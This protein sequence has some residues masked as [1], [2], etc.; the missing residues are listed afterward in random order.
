MKEGQSPI[1]LIVSLSVLLLFIC[2]V[3]GFFLLSPE[4]TSPAMA[5]IST[6][7]TG[8]AALDATAPTLSQGFTIPTVP[9]NDAIQTIQTFAEANSLMLEDYPAKLIA[10][11]ERNPETEEFVLNY[12]LEYGVEHEIDMSEYEDCENVPLFMQ[13]DRRWGYLDYAGEVAGLSGCGPVCL[14]MAAYYLTKDPEMSPDKIIQ[15]AIDHGYAVNGNGSAWSLISEGGRALGLNVTEI[16][17]NKDRVLANLEAGNLIICVMGPGYFT[18]SGHFILMSGTEDGL[19]RI[20]DP[21]SYANSQKLWDFQDIQNQ[22]LN[23]W[24]LQ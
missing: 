2:A 10:M 19:I 21:N 17:I 14:S 5:S 1:G 23:I 3:L 22:I 6:D 24:V 15:F 4:Q 8:A 11:L 13:W 9:P 18:S 20:N 7:P 12:P 16:T